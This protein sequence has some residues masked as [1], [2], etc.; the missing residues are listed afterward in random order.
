MFEKIEKI[1]RKYAGL[2]KSGFITLISEDVLAFIFTKVKFL[3]W[4]PLG[5]LTGFI[6]TKIITIAVEKTA[7]GVKFL[8][9]EKQVDDEVN[10]VKRSLKKLNNTDENNEEQR[11]ANLDEARRSWSRLFKLSG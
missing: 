5:W 11:I 1:V 6:V 3:S 2:G 4:G 9:I 10:D 8:E 7:L